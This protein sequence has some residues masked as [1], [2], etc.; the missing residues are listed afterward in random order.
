MLGAFAAITAPAAEALLALDAGDRARYD[1]IL[2]PTVPLCR[3]IFEEPTFNYKTGIAF[4]AWLNGLQPHFA[5]LAEFQ[6]RRPAAHLIR[7]FE[8][9]A[10]AGALRKPDL[11]VERMNQYL[12]EGAPGSGGARR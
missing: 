12:A 1:A 3:K 8:L 6:G 9:A 5:M 4:L 10:A 2:T 11:A 7:V